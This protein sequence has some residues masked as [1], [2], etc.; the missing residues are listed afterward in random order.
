MVVREG[1]VF[2]AHITDNKNKRWNDLKPFGEAIAIWAEHVLFQCKGPT[3]SQSRS[4]TSSWYLPPSNSVEVPCRRRCLQSISSGRADN[5]PELD[6]PTRRFLVRMQYLVSTTFYLGSGYPSAHSDR[7]SS[8]S[9]YTE[10]P[11]RIV[12]LTLRKKSLR[13]PLQYVQKSSSLRDLSKTSRT[14]PVGSHFKF[15][16]SVFV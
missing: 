2:K 13:N 9:S 10:S 3:K 12:T 7:N 11:A 5:Y 4:R 16:F 6:D 14:L 15:R 1:G 8:S